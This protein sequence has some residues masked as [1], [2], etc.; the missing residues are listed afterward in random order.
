MTATVVLR[1][2]YILSSRR[3]VRIFVAVSFFVT[4]VVTA[5]E[6]ALIYPNFKPDGLLPIACLPPLSA[7]IWRL[8]VPNLILQTIVFGGTLLPAVRLWRKGQR[9]QLLERMVRE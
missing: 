8:Y 5:R 9:S 6:L 1:V 4:V 3:A 2:W 7:R